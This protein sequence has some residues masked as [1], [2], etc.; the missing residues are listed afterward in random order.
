MK[1]IHKL[2]TRNCQNIFPW[3]GENDFNKTIC[4]VQTNKETFNST[5][6]LQS[7]SFARILLFIGLQ[8][9]AMDLFEDLCFTEIP[10]TRITKTRVEACKFTEKKHFYKFGLVA[11]LQVFEKILE[12]DTLSTMSQLTSTLNK[13]ITITS[14]QIILTQRMCTFNVNNGFK[15]T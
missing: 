5:N 1:G 13:N 3:H 11:A 15:T 2:I 6:S 8:Q 14:G 12:Y 9:C 4:R 7:V 10:Q